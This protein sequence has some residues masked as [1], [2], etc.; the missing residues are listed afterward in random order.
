MFSIIIILSAT[1]A[2]TAIS[3]KKKI[4]SHDKNRCYYFLRFCQNMPLIHYE[5]YQ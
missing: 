1:A 2:E 3:K 4:P 5:K